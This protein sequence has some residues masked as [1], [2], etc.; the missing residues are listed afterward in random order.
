MT[1]KT[2]SGAPIAVKAERLESNGKSYNYILPVTKNGSYTVTAADKCGHENS[3]ETTVS[4]ICRTAPT[5]KPGGSIVLQAGTGQDEAIAEITKEIKATD[6]Q[7][8]A[9]A[10]IGDKLGEVNDG[11]KLAVDLG[12]VNLEK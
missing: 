4:V 12:N 11:V 8:G 9:N 5:V 1:A 7:S 6:T 10:P 3:V 2:K